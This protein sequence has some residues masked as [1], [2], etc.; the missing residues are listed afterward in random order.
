DG[1]QVGQELRGWQHRRG[2]ALALLLLTRMTAAS[3]DTSIV[4][5][6]DG[7]DWH[8]KSLRK[9]F[10]KRGISPHAVP[11]NICGFSTTTATGLAIPRTGAGLSQRTC[12]RF[13]AGGT[14]Q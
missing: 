14:F 2:R 9:A 10:K 3:P 13:R 5:F 12:R 1:A 4:L 8:G 6:G 11:L 7:R